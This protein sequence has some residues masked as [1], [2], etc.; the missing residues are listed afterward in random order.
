MSL[1]TEVQTHREVL[2]RLHIL[3]N[4]VLQ[5]EAEGINMAGLLSLSKETM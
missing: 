3:A 5:E 1:R 2:P 4:T